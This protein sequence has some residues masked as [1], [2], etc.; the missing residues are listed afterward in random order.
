MIERDYILRM[1]NLL[2]QA[3]ARILFFK[4]TK[5]YGDAL[6]EVDNSTRSLLGLNVDMLERM[7]LDGLKGIF[8]SDPA[9]LYSKLYTAGA[10]LK[11]KGEI[12][13]L[14]NKEDESVGIYMKSLSLFTE[15]LPEFE[16]L[17][18]EKAVRT[19]DFVIDKSRDYELPSELK[20]RIASY[21]ERLRR[22]DKL[23]DIIFEMAE[24]DISCLQF[25]ISSYERLLLKSDDELS[26]GHLPRDEVLEGLADL[27]RKLKNE[28]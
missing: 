24:D 17:E 16:N 26:E 7:P 10:V 25:G 23:E 19:I 5:N 22:Y 21:F 27:R 13:E 8:G 2:G 28:K 18:H 20:Q 1:F 14:Q 6:V 4:E 12:L 3:V 9:L 15:G 11:E